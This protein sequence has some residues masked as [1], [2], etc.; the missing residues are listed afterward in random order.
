MSIEKQ[1]EENR[2]INSF[3]SR[4]HGIFSGYLPGSWTVDRTAAAAPGADDFIHLDDAPQRRGNDD[5]KEG[6]DGK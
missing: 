4:F 2:P 1:G 3:H 6:D 5:D